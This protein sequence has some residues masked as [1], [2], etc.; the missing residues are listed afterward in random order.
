MPGEQLVSVVR[1]AIGDQLRSVV[2]FDHDDW[3]IEYLRE[4]VEKSVGGRRAL[5]A[6]FVENE[7]LGF[8]SATA[9]AEYA[10]REDIEPA[11]GEYEF[12]VRVFAD[13]LVG[14]VIVGD[15]GVLFTTDSMNL[16]NLEEAA[17]AVRKL[18]S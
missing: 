6:W 7:R 12:T 18:L 8:E 14:R 11:F 1:T 10:D 5:Q 16:S 4:D 15:R 2:T 13:G 3:N 17:V 9:Y